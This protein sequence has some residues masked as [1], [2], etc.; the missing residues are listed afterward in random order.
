MLNF[1][2]IDCGKWK[3]YVLLYK[4]VIGASL[5]EFHT[6]GSRWTFDRHV[7]ENLFFIII[8]SLRTT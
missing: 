7:T 4:S 2:N 1:D 3:Y 6:S 5:S 8:T